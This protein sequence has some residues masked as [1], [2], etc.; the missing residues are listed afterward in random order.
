MTAT[1][2][3]LVAGMFDMDNFG[4]LLFPLLARRR[5]E[6]A[7]YAIQ[8]VA[9]SGNRPAFQDA[10][11]PVPAAE[12]FGD[13]HPVAGILIG[14]GY[15]IHASPLDF[16][17]R[18]RGRDAAAWGGPGMWIGATLAAALRDVPVAWNA[19]GVPHPF[20]ARQRPLVDAALRA[21]SY[22]SVRDQGSLRLLGA[23]A[24]PIAVVPDPVA[25][26]P[27]LWPRHLL[28]EPFRNLLTRKGLSGESRLLAVHVRNRSIAGKNPEAF[29]A[30]LAAFSAGRGLIPMLV[31]VGESH[32]DPAVARRL[33]AVLPGPRLLLDDPVELREVVAA[34]AHSALYVGA[35]LHGYI[36]AMA[37]G[38]PGVLVGCPAYHK[39]AGFLAHIGRPQDLAPD[40]TTALAVGEMPRIGTAFPAEIAMVLDR[41]WASIV[42]A[43]GTPQ[44]RRDERNAFALA[45][46]R[47]GILRDGPGWAMQPIAIRR[48]RIQQPIK[49]RGGEAEHAGT[50]AM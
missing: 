2:R 15:V 30:T 7:G 40:W 42:A 14:G 1:A 29:A 3:I 34:I 50:P 35:S 43:F 18:Y 5:L 49:N 10:I 33:A 4:D 17:E 45:L 31:A 46:L 21:A 8:P 20:T 36:A 13:A 37:F 28:A 23:A 44:A 22:V 48:A 24:L 41:H 19:P 39:F 11:A 47:A 9:P 25:E 12:M 38:V 6:A 27:L 16:L 26:L 32:D